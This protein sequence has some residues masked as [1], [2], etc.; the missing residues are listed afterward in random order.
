MFSTITDRLNPLQ[1]GFVNPPVAL[2]SH[3][4]GRSAVPPANVAMASYDPMLS[5][6]R[7]VE[8]RHI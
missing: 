2:P 7:Q 4:M 6:W 8:R 5:A 3:F 1:E